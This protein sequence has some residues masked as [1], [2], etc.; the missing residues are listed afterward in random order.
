MSPPKLSTGR[1]Y[2]RRGK[3]GDINFVT[4]SQERLSTSP[5]GSE[6]EILDAT[7][8]EKASSQLPIL[9]TNRVAVLTPLRSAVLE[10][11]KRILL[12]Y[13]AGRILTVNHDSGT[14]V[15][16]ESQITMKC[17][18]IL[19]RVGPESDPLDCSSRNARI[20]VLW[21]VETQFGIEVNNYI[22]RIFQG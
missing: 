10:L 5:C 17:S 2:T 15:A 6:T 3:K 20:E 9:S 22:H 16:Q 12:V 4:M 19:P 11:N 21:L 13:A 8:Q 14:A 7:K 1:L 18:M